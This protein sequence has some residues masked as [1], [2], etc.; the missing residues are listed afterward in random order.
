MQGANNAGV[1]DLPEITGT[2]YTGGQ[3][4]VQPAAVIA[5][6]FY[7]G[8]DIQP[9]IYAGLPYGDITISQRDTAEWG[10]IP[11]K[12]LPLSL[13]YQYMVEQQNY[14][15]PQVTGW[16]PYIYDLPAAYKADFQD[17]QDQVVNRYLGTPEQ[18]K[19]EKLINGYYPFIR[20]GYY[21]VNYQFVLPGNVNGSSRVIPYYNAIK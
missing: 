19:Y 9:L 3:P 18:K 6:E 17:L 8:N 14:T 11:L 21:N 1:F 5:N 12:A 15:D 4:L 7:F 16:L 13:G 10:A 2:T 20:E